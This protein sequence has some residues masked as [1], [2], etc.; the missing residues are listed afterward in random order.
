MTDSATEFHL[1]T[2][3]EKWEVGNSLA[4]HALR[5]P[6]WT[7][8][9]SVTMTQ[10]LWMKGY[11]VGDIPGGLETPG[12]SIGTRTILASIKKSFNEE[13]IYHYIGNKDETSCVDSRTAQRDDDLFL[14]IISGDKPLSVGEHIINLQRGQT[15]WR[16]WINSAPQRSRYSH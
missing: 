15:R 1:R 11:I 14:L 9:P 13:L 6:P 2:K 8:T 10:L 5:K 4:A 12:D 16:G 3:Y 7:R